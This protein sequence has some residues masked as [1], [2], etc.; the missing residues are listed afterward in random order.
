MPVMGFQKKFGWGVGGVS[1]LYPSLFLILEEKKFTL[2]SLQ[3]EM[4]KK[5]EIFHHT[6]GVST[7]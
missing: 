2:Q 6:R 3:P 1:E 5:T 7:T 4:T